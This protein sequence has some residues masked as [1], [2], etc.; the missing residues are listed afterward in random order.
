MTVARSLRRPDLSFYSFK[1]GSRLRGTAELANLAAVLRFESLLPPSLTKTRILKRRHGSTAMLIPA[2]ALCFTAMTI[3]A[4]AGEPSIPRTGQNVVGAILFFSYILAALFFTSYI[5]LSI[6]R[7]QGH[8]KGRQKPNYGKRLHGSHSPSRRVAQ[9]WHS[10]GST[11]FCALAFTSFSILSWNMLN[12]LIAS[13]SRWSSTY[14]P[15][16]SLGLKSITQFHHDLNLIWSW[17]TDSSLFQ[18]FAE[19]L[20]SQSARWKIVRAALVYSYT[21]NSWMSAL[22]KSVS[23]K[24]RA[25]GLQRQDG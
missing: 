19:D 7:I 24:L 20:V 4:S 2:F 9:I 21:W 12:F 18:A 11:I 17:A 13:Y 14:E 25:N 23:D 15:R 22:G 1:L 6:Y 5:V 16:T 10:D 8:K 3:S